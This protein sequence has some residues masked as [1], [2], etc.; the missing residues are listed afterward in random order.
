MFFINSYF[1][2]DLQPGAW[3]EYGVSLEYQQRTLEAMAAYTHTLQ[4]NPNLVDARVHLANLQS[5]S[6]DV[7]TALKVCVAMIVMI[8][9]DIYSSVYI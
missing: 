7:D 9:H 5:S 6:G 1:N 4:L 2:H 8:S 3:Y